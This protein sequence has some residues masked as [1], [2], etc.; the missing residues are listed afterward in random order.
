MMW[1]AR[2]L[3]RYKATHLNYRVSVGA[4]EGVEAW[5]VGLF[6]ELKCHGQLRHQAVDTA[7][8]PWRRGQKGEPLRTVYAGSGGISS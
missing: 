2:E 4:T 6:S 5:P 1:G 7:G 3:T 8:G